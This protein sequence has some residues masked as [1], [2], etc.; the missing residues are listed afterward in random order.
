MR[1]PWDRSERRGHL[2]WTYADRTTDDGTILWP[3]QLDPPGGP[4]PEKVRTMPSITFIA[5][6]D[7]LRRS[8]EDPDADFAG[9]YRASLG[10]TRM[11]SRTRYPAQCLDANPRKDWDAPCW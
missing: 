1:S 11:S 4:M 6:D 3:N 10:E 7:A 5:I 8:L 2:L 9:V